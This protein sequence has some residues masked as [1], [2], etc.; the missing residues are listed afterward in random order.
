LLRKSEKAQ[1]KLDPATWQHRMLRDN[2][3]ALRI[4]AALMGD[5]QYAAEEFER[6]D[7]E[8]ALSALASMIGRT[9]KAG[10]GFT[11]GTP[12]HTLQRNR[13]AALLVAE[14]LMRRRLQAAG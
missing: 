9:E 13:L 5:E 1:L 14:Q 7:I 4:A 11:Q 12:Q 2:I 10:A 3:K 6:G 8:E